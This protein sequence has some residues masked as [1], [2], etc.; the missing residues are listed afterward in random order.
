MYKTN[1]EGQLRFTYVK[2]N[3]IRIFTFVPFIFSFIIW[4]VYLSIGSKSILF[5]Y[6][7]LVYILLFLS[8]AFY[9]TLKQL[10]RQN[11]TITEIEFSNHDVEFKTGKILWLNAQ[12]YKLSIQNLSFKSRKF[13]WYGN[14]TE[15]EGLSIIVNNVELFLVKDYFDDYDNIK[16]LIT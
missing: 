1:H 8:F 13:N 7:I 9:S 2:K 14:N 3:I 15:R 5:F 6:L 10:N 4:L 12:D 11:R 16:K